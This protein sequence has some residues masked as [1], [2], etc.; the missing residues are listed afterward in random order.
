MR[1]LADL[2]AKEMEAWVDEEQKRGKWRLGLIS[3]SKRRISITN[4]SSQSGRFRSRAV[5]TP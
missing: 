2:V 5:Y 3:S 4:Q 1:K